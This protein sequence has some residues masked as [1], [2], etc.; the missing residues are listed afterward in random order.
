MPLILK[1]WAQTERGLKSSLCIRLE[2]DWYIVGREESAREVLTTSK[3]A[4]TLRDKRKRK[5]K[6]KRRRR[7][8]KRVRITKGKG[9]ETKKAFSS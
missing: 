9:Q 6:R 5:R 4:S 1:D 3:Y 2:E 7:R 8:R